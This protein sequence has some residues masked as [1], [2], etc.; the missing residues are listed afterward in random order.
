M[1]SQDRAPRSRFVIRASV[2]QLVVAAA[3][4]WLLAGNQP[5]LSEA[6]RSRP[7]LSGAG[8]G[9]AL[10]LCLALVALHVLMLGL[11]AQR[12]AIKPL[13]ALLTLVTAVATWYASR[14][15]VVLDPSMLRN[16][17]RTDVAEAS[18]LIGLPLMLH[19]GL[20]A[21]LPMVLLAHVQVEPRRSWRHALGARALLMLAAAAVLV[22]AV[23]ASYQPLAALMRNDKALR[24][25]VTPANVLWS[26]G[27]VLAADLRGAAKPREPI[28][29]DARPGPAATARQ[30]PLVLVL[31]VGETARAANWGLATGPR[32]DG[33]DTTPRLRALPV[34]DFGVVQA[35]GT[36]TEV[37][38]PCLFAPVG[39]RD[40]DESRIRGQE[41]LLHV[42]A[43]AGVAVHWR[44]NQSGCKGVCDG[45]P[46]DQASAAT[47][48]GLCD[49]D[50]C[51]DEALIAD[52]DARLQRLGTAGSTQVWVLHMLGNHGPAYFKRYPPPFAAYKPECR[53]EDLSRCAPE[54][55][56]NAYDNALRY[57]DEVLARTIERLAAHAGAV[58]SALLF[59]SDH[60]ESLG[61]RG[62]FLHGLPY[63]IAP[64]VQKQVPM[65]F[66]ASAGF[67]RGAGLAA[68][69]VDGP[70]RRR[71]RAGG[72]AHDHVFHTVLGLL[73]VQTALREPALDLVAGC[74]AGAGA[75]H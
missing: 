74:R 57:T 13:L 23:L 17:L 29:L 6:L 49:G 27:S 5:F 47:A 68:G 52:L 63:A 14:Y 53:D 55:I 40:Y 48:P 1:F 71:A 3:L 37:S 65:L 10:S 12:H 33:R 59:V 4:F 25:R 66:W 35:C 11:V 24:Y 38:V 69:C 30:R 18:E 75:P 56:V 2:E 36:N 9:F 7:L 19:L 72:V 28:G 46:G 39:R 42:L 31:V 73:D 64:D 60:G 44:D 16:V 67:E 20:Y 22:G 8:A 34:L 62:L 43:R 61:E 32:A 50:R 21:V 54:A 45:L 70:L 41:S 15:G 51:L 26:T 58:D